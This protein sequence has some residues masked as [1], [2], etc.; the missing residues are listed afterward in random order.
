[1][2]TKFLI[3]ILF[4]LVNLFTVGQSVPNTTTFTL[5]DVVDVVRPQTDD[6]VDCFSDAISGDF[7]PAYSGSKDNLLNFRDYKPPTATTIIYD[8]AGSYSWVCP[9]GISSVT[10]TCI[11][12][13]GRGGEAAS[14]YP[15][16]AGGSGGGL[17]Q[18]TLTVTSGN[19]YSV[20]VGT[21]AIP[22]SGL[23][24]VSYFGSSTTVKGAF[25]NN[26][27]YNNVGAPTGTSNCYGTLVRGGGGGAIGV[28]SSYSGGGGGA[29]GTA[30]GGSNA[31]GST[32]GPYSATYG[33]AGGAGLVTTGTGNNA[34]TATINYGGGGG[35]AY[36]SSGGTIYGGSGT[37]GAVILVY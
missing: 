33:G 15:V 26:G 29:A 12:G 20:F 16:G 3:S 8:I 37:T 7:N 25:G 6:L 4:A 1:M 5:Q 2:K 36:W 27:V 14:L 35:G 11:G 19:S 23:S 31:S 28:N 22:P 18:S 24:S 9:A 34:S 32:S 13:G 30:G 21:G 10:V 17:G